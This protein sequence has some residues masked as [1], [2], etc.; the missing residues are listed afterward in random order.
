MSLKKLNMVLQL[1]FI[2]LYIIYVS[3][4]TKVH[5]YWAG[6]MNDHE[7]QPVSYSKAWIIDSLHGIAYM[8]SAWT[9]LSAH[10]VWLS[11]SYHALI[12]V[13]TVLYRKHFLIHGMY[14]IIKKIEHSHFPYWG[15][16]VE[17]EIRLCQ[18]G[19]TGW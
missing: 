4:I 17:G 2:V 1:S 10:V 5:Q 7:Q 9:N 18:I 15:Y 11:C 12:S 16:L 19:K 14:Q 6:S 8:Y 3:F 13:L